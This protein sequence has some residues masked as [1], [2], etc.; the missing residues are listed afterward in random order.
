M[1]LLYLLG[2]AGL[3]ELD[4][5]NNKLAKK[6]SQ[7]SP[8]TG[9]FIKMNNGN[10]HQFVIDRN[11]IDINTR[12]NHIW[13]SFWKAFFVLASCI[14]FSFVVVFIM[15]LKGAFVDTRLF[16]S[17]IY[18]SDMFHIQIFDIC[19]FTIGALITFFIV[20]SGLR[21]MKKRSRVSLSDLDIWSILLFLWVLIL[22]TI[23]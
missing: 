20:R 5:I 9:R 8:Q 16:Y 13:C 7:N 3:E 12:L 1:W 15:T 6:K 23:F 19:A 10:N 18:E 17:S 4:S 22:C 11:N 2:F 14:G 21:Y